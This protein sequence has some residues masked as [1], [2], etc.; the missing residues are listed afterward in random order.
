MAQTFKQAFCG[1]FHCPLEDFSRE[2]LARCLYPHARA[3]W[4]VIDLCGGHAALAATT[5]IDLAGQTLTKED[6][7]DVISEY[8]NDIKP[9]AGFLAQVFKMRVSIERVIAV[10][11]LVRQTETN[12]PARGKRS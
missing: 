1:H 7:L 11:N 12:L 8:R 5:F 9:H 10:H 6:L 2:A 3:V 4:K